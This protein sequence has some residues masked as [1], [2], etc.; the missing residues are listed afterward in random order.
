ME[1]L[2]NREEVI[3]YIKKRKEDGAKVIDFGSRGNSW[4]KDFVDAIVDL[5]P[6]LQSGKKN[7]VADFNY[8]SSFKDINRYNIS[9][10]SH[11]LE[12]LR[13]PNFLLDALESL[14]NEGFIIVPSSYAEFSY[15]ESFDYL[16]CYHHRWIFTFDGEKLVIYPKLSSL[17]LFFG[18]TIFPKRVFS[19]SPKMKVLFK[20]YYPLIYIFNFLF[21]KRFKNNNKTNKRKELIIHWEKKIKYEFINND[22]TISGQVVTDWYRNLL[23]ND[24]NMNIQYKNKKII[25]N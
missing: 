20:I 10:T 24:K 17:N 2:N 3:S 23:I 5:E 14:S 19:V 11:T 4:T 16:G 22:F 21:K 9:I 18:T 15:L 25:N 12:D 8:P 7:Y 1:L 13:S 6:K